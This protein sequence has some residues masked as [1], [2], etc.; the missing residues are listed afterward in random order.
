MK[1]YSRK[2]AA[3]F[4]IVSVGVYIC[5]RIFQGFPYLQS[6]LKEFVSAVSLADK[7]S[8]DDK[9]LQLMGEKYSVI[10]R[11]ADVVPEGAIVCFSKS[12]PT[13]NSSVAAYFLYPRGVKNV[14]SDVTTDADIKENACTHLYFSSGFPNFDIKV[15]GITL[16]GKNYDDKPILV[17]SSDYFHNDSKYLGNVGILQL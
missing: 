1:M 8:Y 2:V 3:L 17:R 14:K 16:F 10:R 13:I 5:L 9:M 4:T 7:V 12:D 15:K 11:I 6:Y